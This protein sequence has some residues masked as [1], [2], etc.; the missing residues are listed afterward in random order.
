MSGY[1]VVSSTQPLHEGPL[2]LFL[3]DLD[4][5]LI[6]SKAGRL[7]ATENWVFVD[8]H[9]PAKLQQ[10]MKEGWTVGIVTNQ[11]KWSKSPTVTKV[12]SVLAAL[13]ATNGWT[14]WCLVA[15]GPGSTYRKPAS[16]L[17]DVLLKQL[18]VSNEAVKEL[19]YCGDAVG[20]EDSLP[21]FRWA[22]S[23]RLFAETIG[24]CFLRATELWTPLILLASTQPELLI[25]VG[26]SG[27]GKS[28]MAAQLTTL[29]YRHLEQDVLKT[30]GAVQKAAG[31]ALAEKQSVVV[32][33]THGNPK[34]RQVWLEWAKKQGIPCR[35][36]WH[37]RDG[38][39]FNALRFVPVPEIAYAVYS[40]YFVAPSIEEGFAEVLQE[41]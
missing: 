4:G 11:S 39:P 37:T 32:D 7:F 1:H 13:Q 2:K 41:W 40:K 12:E 38:R 31:K 5:T 25:L 8:P 16:G 15:T 9:I 22:A 3:T 36:I 18:G 24:A 29:G 14:P 28:T 6:V 27:S 34:N 26:N 10:K 23:D 20:A 21:A 30:K 33:A 19:V 17:Y 35:C